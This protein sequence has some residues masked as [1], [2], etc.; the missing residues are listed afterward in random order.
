MRFDGCFEAPPGRAMSGY[1]GL[2]RA[3][4]LRGGWFDCKDKFM[5]VGLV[6][7]ELVYAL[8]FLSHSSHDLNSHDVHSV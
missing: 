7:L 3:L 1:A 6:V 8:L 4:V 2:S 5:P